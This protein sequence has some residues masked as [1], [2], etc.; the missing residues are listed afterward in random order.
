MARKCRS[1]HPHSAPPGLQ[2]SRLCAPH[3]LCVGLERCFPLEVLPTTR[4]ENEVAQR[5]HLRVVRLRCDCRAP[6]VLTAGLVRTH[7]S[8]RPLPV[9]APVQGLKAVGCLGGMPCL[10]LFDQL[11]VKGERVHLVLELL[12]HSIFKILRLHL[13]HRIRLGDHHHEW[14]ELM[15]PLHQPQIRTLHPMRRNEEQAQVHQL[16]PQLFLLVQRHAGS[17]GALLLEMR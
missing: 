3:S 5:R 17:R 11:R 1:G 8:P 7:D 16:V 6:D 10:H 4:T 15:Q 13:S 9:T 2:F 14:H 12:A